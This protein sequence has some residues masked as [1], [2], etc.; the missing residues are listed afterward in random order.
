MLMPAMLMTSST[1][2]RTPIVS[3]WPVMTA[4]SPSDTRTVVLSYVMPM[5]DSSGVMS[6]ALRKAAAAKLMPATIAN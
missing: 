2:I 4:V 6:V 3:S 1:S 5:F